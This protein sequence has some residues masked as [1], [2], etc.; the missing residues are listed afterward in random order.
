MAPR[1]MFSQGLLRLLGVQGLLVFSSAL[2]APFVVIYMINNGMSAWAPAIYFMIGFG[3]EVIFVLLIGKFLRPK[4]RTMGVISMLFGTLFYLSLGL[5]NGR[6]WLLVIIPPLLYSLT[7]V[8]FWLPF[9]ILIIENTKKGTRG[10]ILSISFLLFP[11]LTAIA[12]AV[13]GGLVTWFGYPILWIIC[14]VLL[15]VNAVFIYFL[16]GFRNIRMPDMSF[17]MKDLSVPLHL[18]FLGSGAQDGVW[19]VAMPLM[20]YRFTGSEMGLGL[21]I[22]AFAIV[23][24]FAAIGAGYMSDRTGNRC[25]FLRIA[26]LVSIPFI[27]V[28]SVAPNIW[29]YSIAMG[30]TYATLPMV[31]IFLFAKMTDRHEKDPMPAIMAREMGLN[32]GRFIG[33]GVLLVITYFIGLEVA[34]ATAAIYIA[35]CLFVRRET[36]RTT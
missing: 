3:S 33:A 15:V 22:S 7:M 12:P 10:I 2:Q 8:F 36:P 20:S 35:F 21:L 31:Y 17:K 11:V 23:G 19:V 6:G 24:A 34:M 13:A 29:V 4:V 28:A 14:A 26:A 9:N 18:G 16:Q 1:P 30:L 27:I 32:A 5:L 25:R